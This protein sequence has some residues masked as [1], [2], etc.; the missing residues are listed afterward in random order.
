MDTKATNTPK[1]QCFCYPGYFGPRCENGK[2]VIPKYFFSLRIF[3]FYE[4]CILSYEI[5][6]FI[7]S[8]FDWDFPLLKPH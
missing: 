2:S 7:L 6:S 1:K 5:C 8:D 4:I 3:P